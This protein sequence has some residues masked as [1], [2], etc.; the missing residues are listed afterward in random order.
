MSAKVKQAE[1]L[2]TKAKWGGNL[3]YWT[4]MLI[5]VYATE[6]NVSTVKSADRKN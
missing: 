4:L 3:S 6:K 2:K 5:P 1:K